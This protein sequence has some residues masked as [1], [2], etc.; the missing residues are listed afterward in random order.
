MKKRVFTGFLSFMFLSLMVVFVTSC[1]KS[2]DG[3]GDKSASIEGAWTY[4]SATASV[5]IDG[6]DILEFFKAMGLD[7]AQAQVFADLMTAEMIQSS[8]S[9]EFKSD[10]TYSATWDGEAE[11]GTYTLSDDK[12]TLTID[13]SDD[14]AATMDVVTLSDSQL[15][16]KLSETSK[17]DMD[18]DGTDEEISFEITM[19]LKR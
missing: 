10:G 2:E 19:N 13:A 11:T 4:E 14:D 6:K 1:E 15:V 7:D 9:I 17:E 8:G 3:D 16:L 12:K 5:T 18:E